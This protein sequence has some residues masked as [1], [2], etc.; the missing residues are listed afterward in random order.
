MIAFS[1][2]HNMTNIGVSLDILLFR[3]ETGK[4]VALVGVTGNGWETVFELLCGKTTWNRLM[5][6]WMEM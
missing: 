4:I 3:V 1:S 6:P 2:F 5:N